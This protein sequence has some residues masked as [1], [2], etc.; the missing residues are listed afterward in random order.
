LLPAPLLLAALL[1]ACGGSGGGGDGKPAPTP[2]PSPA[3]KGYSLSTTTIATQADLTGLAPQQSD[4]TLTITDPTAAQYGLAGNYSNSGI[5]SVRLS[6]TSETI[7]ILSIDYRAPSGLRPGVYHDT[8]TIGVCPAENC[9]VTEATQ[10]TVIDVNYTVVA[11]PFPTV[12]L[13]SSTVNVFALAGDTNPTPT[14]ALQ[15]TVNNPSAY[16]FGGSGIAT[17]NGITSATYDSVSPSAANL[18]ISFRTP[19]S[20]APGTYTDTI[21]LRLCLD[22]ACINPVEVTPSRVTVN[23]TIR[24]T[25]PGSEGYSFRVSPIPVTDAVWNRTR[26]TL[27]VATPAGSKEH[28]S[29]V[30]ELNPLTGAAGAVIAATSDPRLLALA[31]DDSL[32]Y[33]SDRNLDIIRR[34]STAPLAPDI[35][36][37]LGTDVYTGTDDPLV[38]G[39]MEV[40]PG[41]PRLLAVQLASATRSPRARA[42]VAFDDAVKRAND[43]IPDWDRCAG[44]PQWSPDA[45]HI[46]TDCALL[47]VDASGLTLSSSLPDS[48]GRVHY[49]AGRLF[50]DYG[51]VVDI[52]ANTQTEL[53]LE[54][55]PEIAAVDEAAG[56]VYYITTAR[57]SN[58]ALQVE[59]YDMATLE[60]IGIGRLPKLENQRSPVRT[61][62]WGDDGLAIITSGHQMILVHGP[63]VAP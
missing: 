47:D 1:S 5:A 53:L 61:A 31:D 39:A 56:R 26:Q 52:A 38:A 15:A 14:F 11:Q 4:I 24:D 44:F 2:S 27:Y 45:T 42:T 10:T 60:R 37:A 51:D 35:D 13:E 32:L 49:A 8:V 28:S 30:M 54:G 59:T 50:S 36:I 12:T 20:L 34:F 17:S 22:E 63:L 46:F 41:Q 23:Y 48:A 19:A 55:Y 29:S 3:G 16:A 9:S 6:Y 7:G 18:N 57:G 40:A 25:I 21:D 43:V 58:G 33:V 62:R